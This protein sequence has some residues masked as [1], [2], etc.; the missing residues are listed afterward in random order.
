LFQLRRI[1]RLSWSRRLAVTLMR[2]RLTGIRDRPL[3]VRLLPVVRLRLGLLIG[4]VLSAGLIVLRPS[5]IAGLRLLREKFPR[6]QQDQET[7][8]R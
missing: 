8:H 1:E 6:F 3:H 7:D 4:R 2:K 5:L